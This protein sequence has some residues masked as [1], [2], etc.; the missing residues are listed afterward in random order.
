MK[1]NPHHYQKEAIQFMV[2]RGACG[3]LLDPGL[4]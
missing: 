3:L 1:W 4:G 2:S